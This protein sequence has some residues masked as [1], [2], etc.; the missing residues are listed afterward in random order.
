MDKERKKHKKALIKADCKEELSSSTII[1]STLKTT[2][3]QK[4]VTRDEVIDVL[5]KVI[6][7]SYYCTDQ[8]IL[9][10]NN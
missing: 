6:L 2:P 4:E 9:T 8:G 5:A 1:F 7:Y 3:E 10:W